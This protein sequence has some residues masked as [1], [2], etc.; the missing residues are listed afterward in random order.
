MKLFLKDPTIISGG[1]LM[2]RL[3]AAGMVFAAVVQIIMILF[4]ATGK[5]LPAFFLSISRQGVV[6]AAVLA[7]AIRFWGYHGIIVTQAV[8]DL[9]TAAIALGLYFIVL[10]R[11]LSGQ[12][13]ETNKTNL[14]EH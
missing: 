10:H 7:A 6:F 3:Q 4:Q 1:T 13:P 8:A 11:E 14:I 2:L 5:R 12:E 9:L